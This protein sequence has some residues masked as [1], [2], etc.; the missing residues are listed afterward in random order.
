[1]KKTTIGLLV[2]MVFLLAIGFLCKPAHAANVWQSLTFGVGANGA[3]YDSADNGDLEVAGKAALSVTPHIS[4][5]GGLAYGFSGTYLRE[6]LGARI[7]AT[8]VD[9]QNFSLGLGVSRH[10]ASE[11]GNSLEEWAGEAAVGWK[12]FQTSSVIVTALAAVG[13]ESRTPFITAGVVF[14]VKVIGGGQ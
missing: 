7:T 5:V 11:P 14:P 12:P 13:L 4:L 6:S 2:F 8:D 10:F 1:M 9:D 3:W